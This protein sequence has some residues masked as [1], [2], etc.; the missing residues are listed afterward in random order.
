MKT[1][2]FF[3]LLGALTPILLIF[4]GCDNVKLL[5]MGSY[6][7]PLMHEPRTSKSDAEEKVIS[8]DFYKTN[9]G[10]LLN[11][12]D[13][14]SLGASAHFTYR[15]G[16]DFS[17]LFLSVAASGSYGKLKLDCP[18]YLCDGDFN[19]EYAAVVNRNRTYSYSSMQE[20][21]RVGVEATPGFFVMGLSG[22]VHLYQDSGPFEVIRDSLKKEGI[23]KGNAYRGLLLENRAWLGLRLGSSGKYG[24]INTEMIIQSNSSYSDNMVRFNFGYFH[25]TGWHGGLLGTGNGVSLTAGKS[26]YF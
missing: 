24:T 21:A 13:I 3:K 26:F 12:K 25:P 16:G 22:G 2:K 8:A 5:A 17:W 15:A 19:S 11:T 7:I 23:V 10:A 14:N 20:L 9:S 1:N 4:T 6:P 18:N